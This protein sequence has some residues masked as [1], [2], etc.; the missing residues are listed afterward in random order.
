MRKNVKKNFNFPQSNPPFHR[1][2]IS[3]WQ[4]SCPRNL[5]L[6]NREYAI[7]QSYIC[8]NL[9]ASNSRYSHTTV[10]PLQRSSRSDQLI[11]PY[12]ITQISAFEEADCNRLEIALKIIIH[13]RK[14]FKIH[15]PRIL[16]IWLNQCFTKF[17]LKI[18]AQS[19]TNPIANQCRMQWTSTLI[20][21]VESH[22]ESE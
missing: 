19:C 13:H 14:H 22:F 2:N 16:V 6:R 10:R 12:F 11:C 1:R 8:T 15:L 21:K 18:F 17:I 9:C 20:P 4:H 7:K 5:W 3:R